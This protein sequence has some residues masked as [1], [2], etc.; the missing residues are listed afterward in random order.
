[1]ASAYC[2]PIANS[3]PYK[4][5]ALAPAS[6]DDRQFQLT[7]PMGQFLLPGHTTDLFDDEA[8]FPLRKFLPQVIDLTLDSD[9]DN[10][11]E[12]AIEVG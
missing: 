10:D 6:T 9:G 3:Y 2:P 11:D 12:D 7:P 4:S 1:M 8:F 5:M